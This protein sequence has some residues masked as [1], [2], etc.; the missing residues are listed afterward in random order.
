MNTTN[1]YFTVANIACTSTM[2]AQEDG[3]NL[4]PAVLR[5]GAG[6]Q[7]LRQALLSRGVPMHHP[8]TRVL[9]RR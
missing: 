6:T 7:Q 8:Y 2:E 1:W 9:L 4:P 3:T 5:R